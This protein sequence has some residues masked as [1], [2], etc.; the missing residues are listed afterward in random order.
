VGNLILV[1]GL[2]A[3]LQ[4]QG[5]PEET[6]VWEPVPPVVDPGFMG[7][8]PS[9]AIILFDGTDLSQWQGKGGDARWKVADGAM[10]VVDGA[11]DIRTKRSFG[12]AQLHVEWR[13]PVLVEGEGQERGNSG[14]YLMERYELQVL[15]S[16]HNETYVN[17]QAGSIYKQYAPLVNASRPPGEWQSYDI[18]FMAPRFRADGSLDKPATFT[19]LHNG[20]LIQNHVEVQGASVY[21]GKPVYEPHGKSP[22]LLQDHHNP[23]S[24]RN[25]WIREL[26]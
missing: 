12:D 20:V 8:P 15:D 11:G 17:G 18:I 19:V 9:D 2:V 23:V 5:D 13:T 6:E 3:A 10:T 25:I 14:V 4:V 1:A 7:R 16:Y 21:I 22:L 26:N 24:Y